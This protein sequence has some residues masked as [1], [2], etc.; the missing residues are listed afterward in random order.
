MVNNR[1]YARFRINAPATLLMGGS[2]KKEMLLKNISSQGLCGVTSNPFGVYKEVEIL[3]DRPVVENAIKQ[4]ARLVWK[5]NK[6]WNKCEAGFSLDNLDLGNFKDLGAYEGNE[7]LTDAVAIPFV[8]ADLIKFILLGLL[9]ISLIFSLR[10][11]PTIRP[12]FFKSGQVFSQ[13]VKSLIGVRDNI[14]F[15]VEGILYDPNGISY[16]TI[17][18]QIFS[19]GEEYKNRTIKEINQDSV[20]TVSRGTQQVIRLIQ[21]PK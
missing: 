18:G 4:K 6:L 14:G 10:Q 21:E 3:I 17:N 7:E 11:I 16:V 9:V 20:V 13:K 19:E 8:P 15:K 2:L 12:L 1:Q 5:R